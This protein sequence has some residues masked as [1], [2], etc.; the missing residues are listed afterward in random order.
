[1]KFEPLKDKIKFVNFNRALWKCE[2][3]KR[4][5]ILL[6]SD[7]RSAVE[8][9]KERIRQEAEYDDECR[10]EM[11]NPQYYAGRRDA[12]LYI[13]AMQGLIDMAFVDVIEKPV[14]FNSIHYAKKQSGG[15]K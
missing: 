13:S 6:E 9:L 12:Y 3:P 15:R 2:S 11:S 5:P 8:W 1:M 4:R 7:V 10:K 14:E